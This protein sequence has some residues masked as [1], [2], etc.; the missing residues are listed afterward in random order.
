MKYEGFDPQNSQRLDMQNYIYGKSR[1]LH[2]W[3]R[4]AL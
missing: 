1:L 3:I 2:N 4:I